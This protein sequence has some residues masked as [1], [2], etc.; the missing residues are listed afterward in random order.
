MPVQSLSFLSSRISLPTIF[1]R[2]IRSLP[3]FPGRYM[4]GLRLGSEVMCKL[5]YKTVACVI[6]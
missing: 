5:S 1:E 4:L 6:N 2:A 3:H